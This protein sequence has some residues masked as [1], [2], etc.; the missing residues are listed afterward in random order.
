MF[1]IWRDYIYT[2]TVTSNRDL[3]IDSWWCQKE[4]E[5][6][7]MV[8]LRVMLVS[9]KDPEGTSTTTSTNFLGHDVRHLRFASFI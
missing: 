1:D 6:A 5:F 9:L 3:I 2:L 4:I 8:Q 7:F